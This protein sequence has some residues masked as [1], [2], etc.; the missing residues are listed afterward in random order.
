[1][2]NRTIRGEGFTATTKLPRRRSLAPFPDVTDL[3][4]ELEDDCEGKEGDCSL[5]SEFLRDGGCADLVAVLI[6]FALVAFVAT[7]FFGSY[8]PARITANVAL[9]SI[10]HLYSQ[11]EEYLL[12]SAM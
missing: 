12:L 1:M 9:C 5:A 6:G 3:P 10:Q 2:L 11:A 4:N 8:R 7:A